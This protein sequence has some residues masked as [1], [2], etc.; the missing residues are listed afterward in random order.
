MLHKIPCHNVVVVIHELKECTV[1]PRFRSG[2]LNA[3]SEQFC[4][5]PFGSSN[6]FTAIQAPGVFPDH[7]YG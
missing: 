1:V 2:E 4:Y 6:G 5:I 3:A 7:E